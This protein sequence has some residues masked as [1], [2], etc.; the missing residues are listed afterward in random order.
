M[1]RLFIALA[2]VGL[3]TACENH[4]KTAQKI[5]DSPGTE[6]EEKMGKSQPLTL[7]NGQK[8]KVYQATQNNLVNLQNTVKAFDASESKTIE[9][10]QEVRLD[11]ADGITKMVTECRMSGPAHEAL[12]Y[13]LKP[14][15]N[16]IA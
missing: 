7:N 10:Y 11:L 14:F 16:E 5:I 1:K 8:W 9:D 15:M 6:S 4:Q 3:L 13:W 12:H 2:L